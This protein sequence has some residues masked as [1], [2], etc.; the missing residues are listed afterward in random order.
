M[1]VFG[2]PIGSGLLEGLLR[3]LAFAA[4]IA[5]A[6]VMPRVPGTAQTA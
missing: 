5:A 3:G 4:V 2:D 1:I 6:A